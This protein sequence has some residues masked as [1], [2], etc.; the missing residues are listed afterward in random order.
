MGSVIRA[1]QVDLDQ[2]M[3]KRN[4]AFGVHHAQKAEARKHIEVPEIS[5]RE[6]SLCGL[7][8]GPESD[9]KHRCQF[10]VEAG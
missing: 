10:M 5:N 9:L 6:S 8:Q 3:A 2:A 1:E 4:K 7:P